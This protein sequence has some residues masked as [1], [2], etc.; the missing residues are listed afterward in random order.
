MTEDEEKQSY[1]S[2]DC[3]TY[4]DLEAVHGNVKDPELA[5]RL[6]SLS[7]TYRKPPRGDKQQD[8]FEPALMDVST[9]DDISLMD[10]AVFG[11]GKKPRFDPIEYDLKDAHVTVSGSTKYGMATIFD[12]DI[13]LY[14]VSYLTHEMNQVKDKIKAGEESYLPP[15]KIQPS[16]TELLKYCRRDKGGSNYKMLEKALERLSSTKI[17]IKHEGK[18]MR[19]VGMFSLIG[20][21]TIKTQKE[22]GRIKSIMI[23]IPQWVYDGV[24]R[25]ENPTVLT[26][27]N[28]YFLL[29]QGNHRFLHRLSRKAAGK[30]EANYNLQTIYERS[31]STSPFRSWKAKLKKS[32]EALEKNPLPDYAVAWEKKENGRINIKMVFT[33]KGQ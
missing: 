6:K 26:M 2:D 27:N 24:V 31:G 9:K 18:G 23:D 15:R 1:L 3:K 28:D 29:D 8:L 10:I 7:R 22:T 25:T 13:F 5:R 32:I 30:G 12:Y 16:V 20:D 17:R 19:R 11:L 14:M 4:A 33:G 21:F